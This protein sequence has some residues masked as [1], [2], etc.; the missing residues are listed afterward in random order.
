MNGYWPANFYAH[1][2]WLSLYWPKPK[3]LLVFAY[4]AIVASYG[5]HFAA[6]PVVGTIGVR[7]AL[8]S[9]VGPVLK[10]P[11]LK[12]VEVGTSAPLPVLAPVLES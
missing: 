11:V 8:A 6:G 9:T 7:F 2:Y 5:F 1:N 10:Y 4:T 3:P 12:P